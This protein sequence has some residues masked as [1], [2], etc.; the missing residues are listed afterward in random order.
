[1][2]ATIVICIELS[3]AWINRLRAAIVTALVAVGWVMPLIGVLFLPRLNALNTSSSLHSYEDRLRN[4]WPEAFDLWLHNGTF[5]TG[6]G[7]GGLGT[8]QTYFESPLFNAGD[9]LHLY[10]FVTLGVLAAPLILYV[11]WQVARTAVGDDRS[12]RVPLVLFVAALTY[13]LTANG[14]ENASVALILGF[15]ARTVSDEI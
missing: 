12:Q 6:R 15:V 10:I 5:L 3:S 11:C 13:G 7:L 1:V 8:A 14:I 9:N 2:L 4:M